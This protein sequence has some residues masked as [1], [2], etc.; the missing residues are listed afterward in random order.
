M[1]NRS[2]LPLAALS[3][4][5]LAA[6]APA[7]DKAEA[8]AAARVAKLVEQ[9]GNDDFNEREMASA[10]LDAVGEPALDALRLAVM[11]TDEEV[12][13]RA[14]TLVGK[15][16]KRLQTASVLKAKRVRLI[17]KD[18]A[19]R[20]ALE[21]FGKK[22]GYHLALYDPENKLKNRTITLDT[23]DAPFW[24]AFDQFCDKAG[25]KEADALELAR[26][27]PAVAA[28]DHITLI[29]GKTEGLPTDPASAVRVRVL[30]K[31]DPA[32][33]PQK[34]DILFA[35]QLSLEPRLQ[36][37]TVEK[38]TITKAVD[39]QKQ[40]LIALAD[41]VPAAPPP[42][43]RRGGIAP[44]FVGGAVPL[45]TPGNLGGA[46]HQDIPFRL[47]K[48]DKVSKS[49]TELT[50]TVCASIF[51]EAAP[52]ITAPDIL[53]A[54]GKT[55][56]GGDNGQLKVVEVAKDANG[57][58]TVRVEL[59]APAG[60][61]PAGGLMGR[62]AIR[63]LGRGVPVAVAPVGGVVAV[64]GAG[65][66]AGVSAGGLSLLD[67]KGEVVKLIGVQ[68]QFTA[69]AGAVGGIV[70]QLQ[71]ILTFQ[72]ENGQEASKLIYSGRK[73]LTMEIPFTLKDVPL[74]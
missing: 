20:D 49:L 52:I 68:M 61:V 14:E 17:Y 60:V 64:I 30:T 44:G 59:Q 15:I 63:R 16:E 25:L 46:I 48:G 69:V 8:P 40:E 33:A 24:Q 32:V 29:E 71:H 11:S 22:C 38:V 10:G 65:P 56:E 2:L 34:D 31:T 74:P 45:P 18:T 72:A 43:L 51:T 28:S 73:L 66:G 70:N 9:L 27:A 67:D 35:L 7:A 39:D 36:W 5:I 21:D 12:H 54:A 1:P 41:P 47:K 37:R 58:I 62:G 6:P 13:K 57:R 26:T 19:V 4:Y 3:L 53:K 55:F 42:A 50:G 23:G